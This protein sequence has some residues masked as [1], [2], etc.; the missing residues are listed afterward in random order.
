M[1]Y[2]IPK[3]YDL[4]KSSPTVAIF[5]AFSELWNLL[6]KFA[7]AAMGMRN[8]HTPCVAGCNL[9]R[10]TRPERSNCPSATQDLT[11]PRR[12]RL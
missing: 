9:A 7:A 3:K 12:K 11:E 10:P 6:A 8:S 4:H 1:V 2:P 5:E